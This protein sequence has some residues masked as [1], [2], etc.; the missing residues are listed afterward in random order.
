[1]ITFKEERVVDFLND[2]QELLVEHWM[3]IANHKDERPLDPDFQKYVQLND[4]GVLHLFTARDEGKLVG[5]IVFIVNQHA[6][7]KSWK[8]A[9]S[10]VY[11]VSKE[12][13]NKGTGF[14]LFTEAEMWLKDMGVNAITVQEKI[15]FPHKGMFE[16]IGFKH[17][18]NLYEK[19]I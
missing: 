8:Y 14:F 17:V 6:H 7:Y 18:E 3:E 9:V 2:S 13:R 11:Y 10:D 1:M 19:V 5:Y 4:L 12:H 15:N 16:H